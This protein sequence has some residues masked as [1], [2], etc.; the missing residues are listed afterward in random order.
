[1]ATLSPS[2]AN[3]SRDTQSSVSIGHVYTSGFIDRIRADCI[4]DGQSTTPHYNSKNSS[5]KHTCQTCNKNF[6]KA[7]HLRWHVR[8]SHRQ[9][10]KC[11]DCQNIF[12]DSN[13]FLNTGRGGIRL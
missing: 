7:R 8:N 3:H 5:S 12:P 11:R 13:L 6:S 9:P 2:F 10:L 4:G 1:M